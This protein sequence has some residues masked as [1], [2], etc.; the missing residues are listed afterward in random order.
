MKPFC[1]LC[2][3]LQT[4]SPL[5]LFISEKSVGQL[6]E[7]TGRRHSEPPPRLQA[8]LFS[9][10]SPGHSVPNGGLH[11]SPSRGGVCC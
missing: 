10:A 4:L 2:V 6:Q 8:T 9:S 11:H 7:G 1:P 3:S 5:V